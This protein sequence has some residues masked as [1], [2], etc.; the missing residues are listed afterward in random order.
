MQ[1]VIVMAINSFND[2]CLRNY[3]DVKKNENLG[4]AETFIL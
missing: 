4:Y 2:P 1:Q 3:I